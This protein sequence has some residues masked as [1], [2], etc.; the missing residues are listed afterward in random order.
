[1]KKA[2]SLLVLCLSTVLYSQEKSVTVSGGPYLQNVTE[3][4]FT[5]IW[6]TNMDAV[7]WLEL[8]PDDGTHFYNTEREFYYDTR[9]LGRKPVGKTHRI[10]VN[11]LEPNTVYRYR[12]M[13]KGVAEQNNRTSIIYTAGYGM[14]ILKHKVTT[15]RTLAGKYDRVEFATVNDMHE[16]D[17]TFRKLFKDAAGKYDFVMFNGDMTSSIDDERDIMK[18]Y[19]NSA[20][21][22][23]ARETP[24][25]LSRGNHE[26]RGNDATK[27]K[28]YIDTPTG[29]TYYTF[30]YGNF[31]FI[32]LDGGE[33]KPDSDIR[34]LDIMITEPYV[35]EEAE[36]L[37][38]VV[39]SEDFRNAEVRIAFCHLQPN[40]DGWHG[41][42][43]VSK[44]LV[45][46]LNEGGIDLML[47]GH[48]HKYRYYAPGSTTA[49]FP[50]V[51]NAN[52]Q[53]MDAS[54]DSDRIELKFYDASGKQVRSQEFKTRQ[55]EK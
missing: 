55:C 7:A 4:S 12:I 32:V 44:Y 46:L 2:F 20:S 30:K 53:R 10:T 49:L 24:L 48:I 21:E 31:F 37:K 27:F 5:V 54:V 28:D 19:M 6:T 41:N 36:W 33:D 8:A 18:Y 3:N 47:C 15:V 26:Y 52:L 34:N 35:R 11:G 50:V 38:N 9:G 39:E 17:S 51:C 43:M 1:M 29:K 14:D 13:M 16:N 40:P 23:F 45:P 22:L 42:A 25:Y